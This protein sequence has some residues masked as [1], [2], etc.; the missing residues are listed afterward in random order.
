MKRIIL[1]IFVVW[2]FQINAE[3]PLQ[4]LK[5]SFNIV[6]AEYKQ[7]SPLEGMIWWEASIVENIYRIA[8][9]EQATTKLV[10]ELFHLHTDGVFD[11]ARPAAAA[12][13]SG[14]AA[15]YFTPEMVAE[16]I[17]YLETHKTEAQRNELKN[18]IKSAKHVKEFL[19]RYKGVFPAQGNYVS[20]LKKIFGLIADS[21]LECLP[22]N[23][24]SPYMIYTTH[25]ILLAY[26]WKKISSQQDIIR[27]FRAFATQTEPLAVIPDYYQNSLKV[28]LSKQ[29]SREELSAYFEQIQHK[30][31]QDL[32]NE[33]EYE[34]AL[35]ALFL[36]R[37]FALV[38]HTSGVKYKNEEFPDCGEVSLLNFFNQIV[39][40]KA[41]GSFDIGLL[42]AQGIV[43]NP[44]LKK[45]YAK[46]KFPADMH[47]K[48]VHNE[49]ALVVSEI[50]GVEYRQGGTQVKGKNPAEF[51]PPNYCNIAG[52][53]D[54]QIIK[55]L[56]N[57]IG[58]NS[59][60]DIAKLS[61]PHFVL[62]CTAKQPLQD[63][64]NTF[65]LSING[66]QCLEWVSS[67]GHFELQSMQNSS[68]TQVL[69]PHIIQ[70]LLA[71]P[72]DDAP[73]ACSLITLTQN[74]MLFEKLIAD[75][76][77]P[78]LGCFN[79]ACLLPLIKNPHAANDFLTILATEFD[80]V[81]SEYQGNVIE[82]IQR[83]YRQLPIDPYYVQFLADLII[84][85]RISQLYDFIFNEIQNPSEDL[86]AN[87]GYRFLLESII[88]KIALSHD[89]DLYPKAEEI[90]DGF[91]G[92]RIRSQLIQFIILK[93]E[94]EI[95]EAVWRDFIYRKF[96]TLDPWEQRDICYLLI[97]HQLVDWYPLIIE[98][99]KTFNWTDYQ[100]YPNKQDQ[101]L[102]PQK[103]FTALLTSDDPKIT[104]WLRDKF[105]YMY[106][107]NK[108]Q[109]LEVFSNLPDWNRWIQDNFSSLKK[110]KQYDLE[111]QLDLTA[112]K[113]LIEQDNPVMTEFIK[114]EVAKLEPHKIFSVLDFI[115]T[116]NYVDFFDLISSNFEKLEVVD[117]AGLN[118]RYKEGL[119]EDIILY[120]RRA[121][122]S[123][124]EGFLSGADDLGKASVLNTIVS[125][126][127]KF[128]DGTVSTQPLEEDFYGLESKEIGKLLPLEPRWY[129]L[130]LQW[131]LSITNDNWASTVIENIEKNN[132]TE[133]SEIAQQRKALIKPVPNHQ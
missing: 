68:Q 117:A 25:H 44:K 128:E 4:E 1:S 39:F 16:F 46:Y 109:A 23:P 60:E 108:E 11:C 120:N 18:K 95:D 65:T 36:N 3:I 77:L 53:G 10:K 84:Y 54:Q 119:C 74:G 43:V 93:E 56:H 86:K 123:T 115:V 100:S 130:V 80:Q 90:F 97:Y 113:I 83:I 42:E 78:S 89:K 71:L 69:P 5:N 30:S 121:L 45:F 101:Y 118:H 51:N 126:K 41:T 57:L 106:G 38:P 94:E 34:Q 96:P 103:A 104:Q 73:R 52:V 15:A 81:Y 72:L 24:K 127:Y 58:I 28:M 32:L 7:C 111:V 27:Y 6:S 66:E 13:N 12:T 64:F 37:P 91:K 50:P 55:V 9:P 105:Q 62:S 110:N 85:N 87:F 8:D 61:R 99:F 22:D 29:Y 114:T 40:N 116:H 63:K 122:Y 19:A 88:K 79:F 124:V 76:K 67:L 129:P 17:G 131:L 33:N 14:R 70:E 35:C 125:S 31:A 2:A 133:L 82:L 98:H 26:L 132:I 107:S 59:F 20:N 48:Q 102:P 47:T 21:Y 92:G 112:L 49:W 75:K